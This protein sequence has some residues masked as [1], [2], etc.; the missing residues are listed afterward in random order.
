MGGFIYRFSEC[1]S[2]FF[3]FQYMDVSLFY[4]WRN[5]LNKFLH[6]I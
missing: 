6:G 2:E 5:C 3:F 1:I 4:Y